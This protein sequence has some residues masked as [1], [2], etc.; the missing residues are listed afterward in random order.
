MRVIPW[1][2]SFSPEQQ[3]II[4]GSLLGDGRLECRSKQG[5]ARFRVHH[6]DQQKDYVFWKYDHLKTWVTRAPWKTVWTDKRNNQE[7]ISW[8]FH[9]N[10]TDALKP[11]YTFFYPE[12]EKIVPKN[13]GEFLDPLALAVW[14]MDDGCFQPNS[15]VLNTQ[16]FTYTEQKIMQKYFLQKYNVHTRIHKDR[17]NVRLYFG[18]QERGKIINIIRPHLLST[19]YKTVP[20][21]TDPVWER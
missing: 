14:F 11:W 2:D 9:T 12:K 17:K 15:I 21:T 18:S 19:F 7:Y 10:T 8:F 16:S 13:I 6:S 5:T 1:E 20:V 4:V 3:S